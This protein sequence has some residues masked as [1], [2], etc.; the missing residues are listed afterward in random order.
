MAADSF[1][2]C[3]CGVITSPLSHC[4]LGPSSVADTSL[5]VCAVARRPD[6]QTWRKAC[7][8]SNKAD[9][10]SSLLVGVQLTG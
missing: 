10:P 4:L 3:R 8:A 2:S 7:R 9:R 6:S 5:P 1:G